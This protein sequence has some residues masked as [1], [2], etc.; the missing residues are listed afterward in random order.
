MLTHAQLCRND[1]NFAG[2][3]HQLDIRQLTHNDRENTV[4]KYPLLLA[5]LC[6]QTSP[7]N[8]TLEQTGRRKHRIRRTTAK[9]SPKKEYGRN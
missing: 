2:A 4:L 1:M 8:T 3:H 7:P 9:Q 5:T 6:S